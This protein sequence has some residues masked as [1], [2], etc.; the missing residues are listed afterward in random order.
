MAKLPEGGVEVDPCT[1][2][3]HMALAMAQGQRLPEDQCLGLPINVICPEEALLD[4]ELLACPTRPA[5]LL[6]NNLNVVPAPCARSG[7]IARLRRGHRPAIAPVHQMLDLIIQEPL[8][9]FGCL[10]NLIHAFLVEDQTTPEYLQTLPATTPASKSTVKGKTRN[11]CKQ[12]AGRV[13]FERKLLCGQVLQALFL[14][15]KYST[16]VC[17]GDC[18]APTLCHT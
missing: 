5:G 4:K 18:H 10:G 3:C 6:P 16:P 7:A 15:L 1:E 13:V 12:V 14:G 8:A 11:E 2:N 17:I 9:E